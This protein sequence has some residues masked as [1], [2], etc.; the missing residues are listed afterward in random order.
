M[1]TIA[2]PH[3]ATQALATPKGKAVAAGGVVGLALVA[4]LVLG[5]GGDATVK[6]T[7]AKAGT[8]VVTTV[9]AVV[10]TAS[11]T[12]FV[13]SPRNPFIKGDGSAPASS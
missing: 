8:P 6:A 9:P 3:G 10:P 1:A 7:P 5:G 12:P 2:L 13:P 4:Y 11:T